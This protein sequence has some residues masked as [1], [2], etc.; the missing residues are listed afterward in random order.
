MRISEKSNKQTWRGVASVALLKSD[1]SDEP[2]DDF[3]V[4]H[5][6]TTGRGNKISDERSSYLHGTRQELRLVKKKIFF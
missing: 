3:H 4:T 2:S 5:Q 1:L 6:E